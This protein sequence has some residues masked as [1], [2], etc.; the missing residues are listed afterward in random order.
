L[1]YGWN[2]SYRLGFSRPLQN[3]TSHHPEGINT[4]LRH[5]HT[6]NGIEPRKSV[7]GRLTFT[8]SDGMLTVYPSTTAIALALGPA[9]LRR[10]NLAA[11]TSGFRWRG[12]PPLFSLLMP[13][14]SL[15]TSPRVLALALQPDANAPLPS[16]MNG[17]PCFGGR[18]EPPYIIGAGLHSASKLLRTL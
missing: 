16:R 8:P 9:D 5:P 6:N 13:A 11:E 4:A 14:S 10:T 3:S 2:V 7:P 15:G 1:R 12:F 17:F 18:L